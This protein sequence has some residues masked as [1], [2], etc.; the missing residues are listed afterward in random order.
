[1]GHSSLLGIDRAATEAPGRDT[2]ALGP[3]D[4]SDSGSDV[5]GVEDLDFADHVEPVD[6]AMR[7]DEG[8]T[9]LPPESL[10]GTASDSGG[11]GERRSAGSDAGREAADISTDR[12]FDPATDENIDEDEDP[13]LA[14]VDR[15]L[16]G[17][18]LDEE[19]EIEAGADDE[20]AAADETAGTVADD[21]PE[22]EDADPVG[23][24]R[25]DARAAAGL[26][27]TDTWRGAARPQWSAQPPTPGR[28]NPEPDTPAPLVPDEEADD[29]PDDE[30][31]VEVKD[32][33]RG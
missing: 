33:G 22:D 18:P 26:P 1:M 23:D 3:G 13:D 8:R 20:R 5:A 9:M 17:T 31:D 27:P 32:P 24:G 21:L 16:A 10:D 4:T 12:V 25:T 2:A 28:S 11:T 15:A 29:P 7:S 6:V 14:F 30:G 19:A